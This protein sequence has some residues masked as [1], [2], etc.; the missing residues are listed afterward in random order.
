MP[1]TKTWILAALAVCAR[2]ADDARAIA[3]DGKKK[4]VPLYTDE[5]LRRVSPL[6]DETG[7]STTPA[8]TPA[9][10]GPRDEKT[11]GRGEAYWRREQERLQDKLQPLRE[12]IED[13]R[14]QVEERRRARGV[15]P[16]SDP[17]VRALERKIAALEQRIH[18]AEDQLHERARREGALPGWLR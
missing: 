10:A 17:R 16:Y 13:L 12:R 18:D 9:P 6:R 3:A 5:D 15:L 7:G 11:R 8:T 1:T 14:G 4:D 2:G